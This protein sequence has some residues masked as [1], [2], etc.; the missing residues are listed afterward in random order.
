MSLIIYF[1]EDIII[2]KVKE[3][4]SR[5]SLFILEKEIRFNGW[6]V[7]KKL[8][9]HF[10]TS[11]YKYNVNNNYKFKLTDCNGESR[12]VTMHQEI[13]VDNQLS[14]LCNRP[15]FKTKDW[16]DF[17]KTEI[18]KKNETATNELKTNPHRISMLIQFA[19]EFKDKCIK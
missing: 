16:L 17:D 14:E 11:S 8:S 13:Y 9:G 2:C 7:D 12:L 10:F 6:T 3:M 4:N 1:N 15:E 5:E 18:I 19:N